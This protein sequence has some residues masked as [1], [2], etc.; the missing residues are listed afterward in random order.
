ML[1]T[2]IMSGKASHLAMSQATG[3]QSLLLWQ[4]WGSSQF[5]FNILFN[6]LFNAVL[7]HVPQYCENSVEKSVEK[8]VEIQLN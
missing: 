5:N 8:S 4:T 7:Q 2:K 1:P 3:P 6:I